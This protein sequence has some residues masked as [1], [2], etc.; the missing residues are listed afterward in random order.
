[1]DDI[2]QMKIFLIDDDPDSIDLTM[3]ILKKGGHKNIQTFSSA[4]EVLA[5]AKQG[6]PDLVLLDIMMP[7]MDGLEFCKTFKAA[8]QTMNIPVIMISGSFQDSD[9]ALH[10][11]FNAGA[12]DFIPKPVRTHEVLARVKSALSLKLANDSIRQDLSKRK[13]LAERLQTA[14]EFTDSIIETSLCSIVVTDSKG[15]ITRANDACLQMLGFKRDEVVGTAMVKMAPQGPGLYETS[16]GKKI[17]LDDDFFKSARKMVETLFEHGRVPRFEGCLMRKDGKIVLTDE[18]NVLIYNEQKEVVGAA[19]IM[20]DITERKK[21]EA[22]REELISRLEVALAEIK[23]L[24]GLLPICSNC[25][26][27]RDDK[28]Y[29]N[30]IEVY[31]RD[32]SGAKFSHGICPECAKKL[33]P[34]LCED[35]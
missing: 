6:A 17:E 34:D 1:M 3:R 18:N 20:Q 31:I 19:S 16:I 7:D 22:D 2:R 8:S 4:K 30:Q 13:L 28:G 5:A 33:Y 15:F 21:A 32:H 23:T 14:L 10:L 11:A 26:K 24:G 25:K 9:E 12:A 29:W 35:P 27:I